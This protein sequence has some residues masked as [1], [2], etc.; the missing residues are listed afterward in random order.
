MKNFKFDVFLKGKLV[1]L[2]V[3]N[4]EIVDQTDWYTWVNDKDLTKYLAQGYFPNNKEDQ[5]KYYKE[6]ILTKKRLQVG[7][8]NKKNK[9]LIGTVG[10]YDFNYI[11]QSCSISTLMN[12]NNKK[13]DSI[14]YFIESQKLIIDH[15]FNKLNL[16]RIN[17][18]SHTKGLRDLNI[19]LLKYKHEGTLRECWFTEG[20]FV[21]LYLLGLLKKDWQK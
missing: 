15:A 8:L 20:N 12:M 4:E 11:H 18:S 10:L 19:K 6:N 14:K 7:I 21:D 17:A 5:R 16:R 3:L 9:D 1:D 13:I 2:I